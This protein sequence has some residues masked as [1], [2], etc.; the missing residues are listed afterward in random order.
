MEIEET[1]FEVASYLTNP[2]CLARESFIEAQVQTV[3]RVAKKIF[4]YLSAVFF[5]FL[6][7]F[8]TVPGV[9]LRGM[10]SWM[11]P[12]P[13][14]V[15]TSDNKK[16]LPENRSFTLLSWNV[17]CV[18]AGY[19]ITDGGVIPW[20]ERID[21]IAKKIIE[22]NSDVNCLYELF[23]LDAAL[24]L[25]EKLKEAGYTHF[26]YNIGPQGIGVSSGMMVASKY[27][28][29][30]PE[31]DPFPKSTLV[32]RTQFCNKGVFSFDLM[33]NGRSFARIFSTHLQHSE[34]PEFP[35]SE[36]VQARASQMQIIVD[37]ISR[38][39]DRCL[40]LTGDLNLDEQECQN[41]GWRTSFVRGN[42]IENTW[43]GDEFCANLENKPVSRPMTLD[44]TFF[45]QDS[46][47]AIVNSALET[48]YL[49]SVYQKQAMSDHLGILSEIQLP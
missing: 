42:P 44:Y 21:A 18:P 6:A 28:T 7:L 20:K 48:G 40:V 39:R 37:K 43:G 9:A 11:Q 26:Y 10:A 45:W 16:V 24:Y 2:I 1:F 27:E 14:L 12:Q 33:S 13:F 46:G 36:E 47:A 31:F 32:G 5:S 22:K 49:A 17:C 3:D 41:S 8:T 4:L 15:Q 29:D 19:S 38:L 35:T 25:K 30:S 34:L 23:D